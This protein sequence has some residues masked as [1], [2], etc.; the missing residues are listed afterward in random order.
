MEAS[1]RSQ[2]LKLIKNRT[3]WKC[4]FKEIGYMNQF[5]GS[6]G[7]DTYKNIKNENSDVQFDLG[8]GKTFDIDGLEERDTKCM[9][10]IVECKKE[11]LEIS[12]SELSSNGLIIVSNMILN[13]NSIQIV[14]LDE[15]ADISKAV[16]NGERVDFTGKK[17]NDNC[18]VVI[19]S[20]LKNSQT[21]QELTLKDN[22]IG[23]DGANQL[24]AVLKVNK[25]LRL[26]DIR[27]NTL[28][29]KI[30]SRKT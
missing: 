23:D 16:F 20:F 15:S 3:F 24:A 19:S 18:C 11:I 1:I 30:G 12:K 22:C 9:K 4:S 17:F 5:F 26:F 8:E 14:T 25:I 7:L 21:V 28:I 2:F 29:S 6:K 13:N 27:S 10:K